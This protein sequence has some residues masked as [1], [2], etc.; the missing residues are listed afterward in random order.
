MTPTRQT[1]LLIETIPSP[2]NFSATVKSH[3]WYLLRPFVWDETES[4]LSRLQQL[5]TGT[6][7]HLQ[8]SADDP[9]TTTKLEVIAEGEPALTPE[10]QAEIRQITRRMLRLDEDLTEFYHHQ[11]QLEGWRLDLQPGGGRLLRCPTLFEDVIYTLCTTNINWAGTV[12]MVDRIVGKLGTPFPR[13]PELIAFPT[14]QAIAQ[15]GPAFLKQETGL[16]YRSDYVWELATAIVEGRL[17]LQAMTAQHRSTEEIRRDLLK[18]K[19]IG[20]YAT[21]TILML[22]GRYEYLAIDSEMR[23]LVSEKYFEGNRPT[24]AQIRAI[25][26]PWERWQY[27][28]YWFDFR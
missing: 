24:D 23:S 15:V 11:D 13:K 9:E 6:V 17:D 5:S 3:G 20:H 25:Y 2:F 21:A 4:K 10:D 27:L 22:L 18:L 12:R 19:G 16:G 14:P 7:V 8:I 26:A 28:A 1:T